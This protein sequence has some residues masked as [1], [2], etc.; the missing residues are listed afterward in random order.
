M[1]QKGHGPSPASHTETSHVVLTA[2]VCFYKV[3]GS[4][5][6]NQASD[7]V[8]LPGI[9]MV[10]YLKETAVK[11]NMANFSLHFCIIVRPRYVEAN[12]AQYCWLC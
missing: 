3:Q 6:K 4:V 8:I 1:Q 9:A 10:R 12:P 7:V 11:L 5:P 2:F